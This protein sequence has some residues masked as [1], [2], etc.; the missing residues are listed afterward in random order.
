MLNLLKKIVAFFERKKTKKKID[1]TSKIVSDFLKKHIGNYCVYGDKLLL[2]SDNEK[3]SDKFQY[4]DPKK[5]FEINYCP[6][7]YDLFDL[8]IEDDKKYD[9]IFAIDYINNDLDLF[10][11]L[12]DCY[13]LL[14][15]EG[16]CFFA[17]RDDGF[18]DEEQ[19]KVIAE[20]H[21]FIIA[22]EKVV[23]DYLYLILK[24]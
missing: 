15:D 6:K 10:G 22:V 21:K 13:R 17:I 12:K 5:G 7:D 16:I 19:I 18:Y 3:L 8:V 20:K 4:E 11:N 14:D 9:C 1:F 2:I 23:G 24:K